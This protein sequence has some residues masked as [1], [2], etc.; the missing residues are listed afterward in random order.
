MRSIHTYPYRDVRHRLNPLI[1]TLREYDQ[2]RRKIEKEGG[3]L[4]DLKKIN[5]VLNTEIVIQADFGKWKV[6]LMEP[7]NLRRSIRDIHPDLY[8]DIR[9][10]LKALPDLD[11]ETTTELPRLARI[12]YQRLSVTFR[13]FLST[14]IRWGIHGVYL[15]LWKIVYGNFSRMDKV[16][17]V[18]KADDTCQAAAT[19]FET[20]VKG[21]IAELLHGCR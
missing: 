11:G 6:R 10:F 8:L 5:A 3:C 17:Q 4:E 18:F 20:A 12:L 21:I 16:G 2:A 15:P 13:S 7:D 14:E 1:D 19:K 9:V